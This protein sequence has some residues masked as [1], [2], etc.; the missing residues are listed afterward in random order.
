MSRIKSNFERD[1]E[2]CKGG[3]LASKVDMRDFTAG[4][5]NAFVPWKLEDIRAPPRI[6]MMDRPELILGK[7]GGKLLAAE[8]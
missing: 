4:R 2:S 1:K 8:V 5:V 3:D 7:H 6:V